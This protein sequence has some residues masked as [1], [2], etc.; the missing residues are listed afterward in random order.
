MDQG[1]AIRLVPVVDGL[2]RAMFRD[3]MGLLKNKEFYI[4]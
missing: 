3:S 1:P 2:G 4:Q